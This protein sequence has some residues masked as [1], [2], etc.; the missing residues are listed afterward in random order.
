[1][2][3]IATVHTEKHTMMMTTTITIVTTT[4]TVQVSVR[5]A[6]QR[7]VIAEPSATISETAPSG[8]VSF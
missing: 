5:R 4:I 1:M 2:M 6:R 3:T 8:A 7:K